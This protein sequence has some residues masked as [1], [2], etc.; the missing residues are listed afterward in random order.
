MFESARGLSRSIETEQTQ[1]T[2]DQAHNRQRNPS[3]RRP[4]KDITASSEN[5]VD[6]VVLDRYQKIAAAFDDLKADTN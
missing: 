6:D 1:H 2:N 4:R 3:A 5:L